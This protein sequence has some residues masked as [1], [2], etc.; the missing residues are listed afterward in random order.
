MDFVNTFFHQLSVLLHTAVELGSVVYN[1]AMF[2]KVTIEFLDH[3]RVLF[4]SSSDNAKTV[5]YPPLY[6]PWNK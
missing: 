2:S 4:V 3:D 1:V 5:G 6:P